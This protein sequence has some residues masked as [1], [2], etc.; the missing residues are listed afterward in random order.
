M[1]LTEYVCTYVY[2]YVYMCT[3]IYIYIYIY[4]PIKYNSHVSLY[5]LNISISKTYFRYIALI[6]ADL[7][8]ATQELPGLCQLGGRIL[9]Q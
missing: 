7:A 4:V 2:I 3:F 9:Y 5:G 6:L 8:G 1:Y